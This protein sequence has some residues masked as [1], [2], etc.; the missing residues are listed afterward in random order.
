MGSRI[1]ATP[2]GVRVKAGDRR[3][4]GVLRLVRSRACLRRPTALGLLAARLIRV[5]MHLR[6]KAVLYDELANE[7]NERLHV[8]L[9]AKKG[10]LRIHDCLSDIPRQRVLRRLERAFGGLD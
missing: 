1:G 7:V 8:A 2:S 10:K 4:G 9:I 6:D 5:G 3:R